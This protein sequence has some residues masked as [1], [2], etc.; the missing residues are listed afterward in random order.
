MWRPTDDAATE[1]GAIEIGA[2]R[3]AGDRW[4][5]CGDATATGQFGAQ[6]DGAGDG[7]GCPDC[8]G[9]VQKG[10]SGCDGDGAGCG[11]PTRRA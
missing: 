7:D 11:V 5:R 4:R 2:D 9:D 3:A 6:L 8:A 10:S 1:I